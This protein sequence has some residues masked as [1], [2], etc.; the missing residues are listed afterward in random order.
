[1]EYFIMLMHLSIY[2]YFHSRSCCH[3]CSASTHAAAFLE[4]YF[5]SYSCLCSCFNS[6]ICFHQCSYYH[7]YILLIPPNLL[8]YL[9]SCFHSGSC[10][11]MIMLPFLVL[12][13][14][15][16]ILA[17]LFLVRIRLT[18]GSYKR[19][20]K[21]WNIFLCGGGVIASPTF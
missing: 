15:C 16:C 2:S 21:K 9:N 10:P 7:T 1:M 11:L 20:R 4:A 8:L 12:L 5:Q 17:G 14:V 3:S 6:S 19:R 18:K 13:Q